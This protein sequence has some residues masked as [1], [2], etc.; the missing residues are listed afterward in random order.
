VES[1]VPPKGVLNHESAKIHYQTALLCLAN[2]NNNAMSSS[3][4]SCRECRNLCENGMVNSA[5][6]ATEASLDPDSSE[7]AAISSAES[8]EQHSAAIDTLKSYRK[9]CLTFLVDAHHSRA[10]CVPQAL[11]LDWISCSAR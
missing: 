3:N 1:V 7:M 9:L 5:I 10:Q 6:T 4:S 8:S 2:S 11:F